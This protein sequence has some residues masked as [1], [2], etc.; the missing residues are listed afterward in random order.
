MKTTYFYNPNIIK[1]PVHR[2]YV[3]IVFSAL[4]F[5]ILAISTTR[6]SAQDAFR[7]ISTSFDESSQYFCSELTEK[8]INLYQ[9]KNAQKDSKTHILEGIKSIR[10]VSFST[11]NQE[12]TK[13]FI[14]EIKKYYP[15][16]TFNPFKINCSGI[17]NRMI[18]L[19]EKGDHFSDLLVINTNVSKS[20]LVEIQGEID[21]ERIAQLNKV[22]NLEGIG[23][24]ETLHSKPKAKRK[25]KTEKK[26]AKTFGVDDKFV[27][28]Q[29]NG[30]VSVYNRY[31]TELLKA[32]TEPS[33]YVN[34]FKPNVDFHSFLYEVDPSCIQSINVQKIEEQPNT[35]QIDILLKGHSEDA[36][37]VCNGMLYFGQNGFLQC[38]KIDD[39]C[40]PELLKNCKEEPLSTILTMHPN[41]IKSIALTTDPPNCD[42]QLKGEFVVVELK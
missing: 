24:L 5:I 15:I 35:G 3:T 19:K 39:D 13:Q 23:A 33:L 25:A 21:L 27:L 8:T 16:E 34:G 10:V 30:N 36:Y 26:D 4:L 37:T 29:K 28:A 14:H 7:K 6:A 1:C 41:Q 31:G 38:I 9:K 2:I 12:Q 42:G 18:Y 17:N 20:S 32:E 22:I 11:Q 40:S